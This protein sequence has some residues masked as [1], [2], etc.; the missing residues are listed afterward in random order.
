MLCRRRSSIAARC[1]PTQPI[2]SPPLLSLPLPDSCW[3]ACEAAAKGPAGHAS[4]RTLRT[5]GTLGGALWRL[6]LCSFPGREGVFTQQ[7]LVHNLA[8]TCCCCCRR[9][10]PPLLLIVITVCSNKSLGRCHHRTLT[11]RRLLPLRR[12]LDVRRCASSSA[13]ECGKRGA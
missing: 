7:Q 3:L 10:C 8:M 6:G 5:L 9:H 11:L 13:F 1:G 4:L 2:V 12:Q